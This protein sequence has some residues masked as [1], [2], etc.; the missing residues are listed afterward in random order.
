MKFL[1]P[2]AVFATLL[3]SCENEPEKEE[4]RTFDPIVVEDDYHREYYPGTK[5]LKIEGPKDEN[6][7][8]HGMWKS[9]NAAG[10]ILSMNEFK[11][12]KKHGIILVN[13]ISGK[14]RY[15]GE[16]INDEPSGIWKFYNEDGTLAKEENYNK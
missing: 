3:F 1:I 13:Y 15:T 16:Y 7:Q 6:N 14:T 8:R 9:Y 5:Q 4:K 11:N 12:G 2:I 10:G